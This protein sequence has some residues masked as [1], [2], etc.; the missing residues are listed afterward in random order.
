MG[1]PEDPRPIQ[2]P[3]VLSILGKDHEQQWREKAHE[4]V[5]RADNSLADKATFGG[6]PRRAEVRRPSTPPR[7]PSTRRRCAAPRPTS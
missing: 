6:T 3:S 2:Y 1:D 4:Q 7:S 5:S